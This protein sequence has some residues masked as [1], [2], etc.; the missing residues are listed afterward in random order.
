M[1]D[2]AL[3]FG[4]G[5]PQSYDQ[6]TNEPRAIT[7][8][9]VNSNDRVRFMTEETPIPMMSFGAKPFPDHSPRSPP[10]F[11]TNGASWLR[12]TPQQS[13]KASRTHNEGEHPA[14]SLAPPSKLCTRKDRGMRVEKMAKKPFQ[15][16]SSGCSHSY[17]HRQ[18]LTRHSKDKHSPKKQ[19]DFCDFKWP[20]G[21]RYLYST[22]LQE[23]HPCTVPHQLVRL[24]LSA[25]LGADE[26]SD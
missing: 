14:F 4:T 9:V 22:H 10:Y 18:G 25:D 20:L 6:M 23:E 7:D 3:V 12:T 21:R 8:V 24:Q 13:N 16:S 17:A 2:R 1:V 5:T 11:T 19:C 26:A 15:C